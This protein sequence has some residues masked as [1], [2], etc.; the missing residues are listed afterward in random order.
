MWDNIDCEMSDNLN[1]Y[2]LI[3]PY[4]EVGTMLGDQY[5]LFSSLNAL[6]YIL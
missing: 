2:N 4:C 1:I 3:K 5:G 6:K